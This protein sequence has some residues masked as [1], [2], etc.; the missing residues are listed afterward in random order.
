L[1]LDPPN[2]TGRAAVFQQLTRT[3]VRPGRTPIVGLHGPAG[4]GKTALAV[5]VGHALRTDFPDGQVYLD[6]TPGERLWTPQAV[7]GAALRAVG[8]PDREQPEELW[9]RARRWWSI[10][11][12]RRL[13]VVL[14]QALEPTQIA[15]ILPSTP[16]FEDGD[17]SGLSSGSAVVIT[18]RRPIADLPAVHWYRLGVL[19]TED[20]LTLLARITGSH[21]VLAEPAASRRLLGVCGNLPQLIHSAA[22]HLATRPAWSVAAV[23][24]RLAE[25]PARR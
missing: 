16:D 6:L 21:R 18:S 22:A 23:A 8:V 24:A 5:R 9:D 20:G 17:R 25:D 15:A 12:D 2:F 7:L 13:F 19:P 10:L 14:D 11:A 4:I 1:P 3:L